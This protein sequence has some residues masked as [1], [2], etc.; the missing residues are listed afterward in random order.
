[1]VSVSGGLPARVGWERSARSP[2]RSPLRGVPVDGLARVAELDRVGRSCP[3]AGQPLVVS[4]GRLEHG[5]RGARVE[6]DATPR[7][8]K[9]ETAVQTPELPVEAT[10]LG[11]GR[12]AADD[13][14]D[15]VHPRSGLL[16]LVLRIALSGRRATA[17]AGSGSPRRASADRTIYR[18]PAVDRPRPFT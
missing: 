9:Q 8:T 3:A 1:M 6:P 11:L 14:D 13:H 16:A 17:C 18:R 7:R 15:A 12:R 10:P 2:I 5:D 4:V